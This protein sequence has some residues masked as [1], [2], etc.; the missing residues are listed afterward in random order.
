M[1]IRQSFVTNSSSSSYII[2]FGEVIDQ[3]KNPFPSYTEKGSDLLSQRWFALDCD[4]AGIYGPDISIIDP[5]KYYIN[6]QESGDEPIWDDDSWEY[7][8]DDVDL[9]W[10]SQDAQD[11]YTGMTEE[12]G[13]KEIFKG[14]GAG[15]DG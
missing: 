10:F 14:F 8:Y 3:E 4:W 5:E 1:K 13:I 15:R 6:L 11:V 7:N 9:D 2:C 12:N